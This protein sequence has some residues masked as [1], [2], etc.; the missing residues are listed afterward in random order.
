MLWLDV[1]YLSMALPI[2]SKVS[3]LPRERTWTLRLALLIA[4]LG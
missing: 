1:P 4:S 3:L 2:P